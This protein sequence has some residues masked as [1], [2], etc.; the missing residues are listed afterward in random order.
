MMNPKYAPPGPE[1]QEGPDE[2]LLGV[3]V[4]EL[5]SSAMYVDALTA[6]REYVQNAADAIDDAR[7]RGLDA[8]RVDISID[9]TTRSV[10]IRD[11]GTGLSQDAF[12]RRL[13]AFGASDKRHQ[14]RRGFRGVGRLAALGHCQELIFRSQA[15]GESHISELR[16]DGRLLRTL[17]RASDFAG[18][19]ADAV[20]SI[21]AHRSLPTKT[22]DRF[23][24]VEMRGVVRHA[25]DDLL[26]D[27]VVRQYLSEVSPIA[28]SPDFRHGAVINAFLAERG[29]RSD[30]EINVNGEGPLYRPHRDAVPMK[31]NVVSRFVQPEFFEIPGV[32][33]GAAACGWVLHH[34]YL[35]AI[36][37]SEA[38]RGI[39]LRS[40]NIQVGGEDILVDVFPE[41]RFNAWSVAEIYVLDRRVVPN[42]RRDNYEQSTHFANIVNHVGL[43]ARAITGRC[44]SESQNRQQMRNASLFEER[45][46]RDLA[47]LKQGAITKVAK[48]QRTA[49]ARMMLGKLGELANSAVLTDTQRA[50][51]HQRVRKLET[52]L[53]R[54]DATNRKAAQLERLAPHRRRAYEEVFSLL[55]QC[56]TD[57]RA[58]RD[59]VER[60]LSQLG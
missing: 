9:P 32:D 44:R 31:E 47:I 22:K 5:L 15:E 34:D 38:V 39:R 55:Y 56:S 51:V 46:Q 58:A 18:S 48:T 35:G 27:A 24:E 36:P 45:I 25:K 3:D 10:R 40:N 54:V 14:E 21:T 53:T 20:R 52:Q 17:L 12:V 26:N 6:Y 41:P 11:N 42:G 23:F 37:R 8:G 29:V 49:D 60:M 19:L 13:T 57:A 28:F 16:W 33:G 1:W 59:L 2:I 7:E 50:D 43:L 30:L 4:V